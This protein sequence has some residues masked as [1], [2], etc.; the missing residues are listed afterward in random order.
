[1]SSPPIL[2]LNGV[3]KRYGRLT[4][5]D[6]ISFDLEA[7]S[8]VALLGENG[9]GK[10]TTFKCVLG[11][12][13]FRGQ[14][15]VAGRSAAKNGKEV[16][17]LIGYLPQTPGFADNDT[18]LEALRF[19]AD[20][21][22]VPAER[23]GPLLERV[24]LVT[25][26]DIPIRDL[27]GGMGQRLAL[28]AALLSDPPLLLLDEPTANLDLRSRE[29]LHDSLLQLRAEGRTV[30]LS[31]HFVEHVA[32][33]ADRVILLKD[34]RI[35]LDETASNLRAKAGTQFTVH[36]NGAAPASFL[37]ALRTVGIGEERV[38]ATPPDLQAAI[39]RALAVKSTNEGSNR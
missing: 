25:Q 38:S 23:I 26:R 22:R 6:G 12:T 9:A 34:G 15:D 37:A 3:V 8:I 4:V 19:L 10:T 2:S 11:M 20:L 29:E 5:L 21:R 13:D 33:I 18:C 7:G 14:I 28:A 39:R 32:D 17:R 30:V 35:E 31:T 27:S 1:V 24:N 16:R 36:L